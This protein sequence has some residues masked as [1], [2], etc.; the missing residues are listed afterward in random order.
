MKTETRIKVLAKCYMKNQK[1]QSEYMNGM[2]IEIANSLLKL[3]K[4]NPELY[5]EVRSYLRELGYYS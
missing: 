4:E 2:A 1:V 5:S 3:E